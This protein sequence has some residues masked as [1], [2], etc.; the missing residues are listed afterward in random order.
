MFDTTQDAE[1]MGEYKMAPTDFIEHMMSVYKLFMPSFATIYEQDK[2]RG[3][4]W[5][6][7]ILK[8]ERQN[9]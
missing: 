6:A 1:C 7:D 5:T 8:V 9:K 4:N 2:I 3:D